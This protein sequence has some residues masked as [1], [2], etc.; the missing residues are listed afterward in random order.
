MRARFTPVF[1]LGW[2]EYIIVLPYF[3]YILSCI[4]PFHTSNF[5]RIECNSNNRYSEMTNIIT[6][7]W[8]F[9][10]CDQNATYE[11]NIIGLSGILD[12]KMRKRAFQFRL[13]CSISG[14]RLRS[15]D[16]GLF[17]VRLLHNGVSILLKHF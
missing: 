8:N 17:R 10:R 13:A 3:L 6:H 14:G 4:Y 5:G 16:I 1:G 9:I 2:D 12:F 11:T 15:Y 7:C